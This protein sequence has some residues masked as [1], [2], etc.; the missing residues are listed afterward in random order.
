MDN[1]TATQYK[2]YANYIV[3]MWFNEV[4]DEVLVFSLLYDLTQQSDLVILNNGIRT[5]VNFS[6]LDTPESEWLLIIWN[7][8]I[9]EITFYFIELLSPDILVLSNSK[10]ECKVY[11]RKID[12]GFVHRVLNGIQ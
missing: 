3:G 2:S 10:K 8:Q 9:N 6:I 5:E 12:N 1:T 11:Q 7:D 4:C